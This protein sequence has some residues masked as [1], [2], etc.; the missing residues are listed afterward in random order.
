MICHPSPSYPKK[1]ERKGSPNDSRRKPAILA[2]RARPG[3]PAEGLLSAGGAVFRCALGRGG[4][5]AG[6]REGDG[7]TPL[8]NRSMALRPVER[9]NEFNGFHLAVRPKVLGG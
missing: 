7:G 1:R 4:I 5:T 2:V 6:K 3:H 9:V 8:G